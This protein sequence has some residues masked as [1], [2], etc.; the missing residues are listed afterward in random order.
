MQ[1][2]TVAVNPDDY[3]RIQRLLKPNQ[4]VY[5]FAKDALLRMIAELE[6]VTDQEDRPMRPI[7]LQMAEALRDR[8]WHLYQ[9]TD[10]SDRNH[11]GWLAGRFRNA[12]KSEILD[13]IALFRTKVS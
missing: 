8:K 4:T 13:A 7:V 2:I 11:K 1:Q 10:Y 6:K 12:T 9:M 5:S 3:D